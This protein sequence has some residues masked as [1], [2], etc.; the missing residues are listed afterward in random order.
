MAMASADMD[1][2]ED[3][4]TCPVCMNLYDELD[5]GHKP[6]IL[7][8]SHTLCIECIKVTISPLHFT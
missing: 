8:C 5:D 1:D 2:V 4:L 3:L 7:S 6:K